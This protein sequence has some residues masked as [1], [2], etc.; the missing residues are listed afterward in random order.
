MRILVTGGAGFIGSHLVEALLQEGHEVAV[1][2]NLSTGSRANLPPTIPLY[3]LDLREEAKIQAFFTEKAFDVI[4]HFSAQVDVRTSLN[5]PTVDAEVNILGTLNLLLAAAKQRPWVIFAST[6]GAI[7][8]EKETLPLSET[9]CPEPEAPYGIAK[10]AAELYGDRLMRLHGGTWTTLRLANVYGP[11]QNPF[12]EAGVVAIFA[13][14]MLKGE[15]PHIY[16][17]GIQTR[18]F[19]YVKDV[20]QACLSV[21][22]YPDKTQGQTFNVGTGHQTSVI[23]LYHHIAEEIGFKYP[24]KHLPAKTGELR[25]NA[26]SAEKLHHTTGWHPE[27]N[28]VEGIRQTV[29]AFQTLHK[30]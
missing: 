6:G 3:E 27:V 30:S 21:L 26:L 8:G 1:L 29:A 4:Y 20:V 16:G 23:G 2:D 19:I 9:A 7:Y 28:L 18:D 14:R 17:D 12:G 13:Y 22:K 11:R 5:N 15:I 25:H 10:L 24:P